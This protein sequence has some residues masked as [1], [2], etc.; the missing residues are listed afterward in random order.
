[1][2]PIRLDERTV[3][4]LFRRAAQPGYRLTI[5]LAAQTITDA[6]GLKL[7]F[8]IDPFRKHCLYNGLDDIGLTLEQVD[9]IAAYEQAHGMQ[10]VA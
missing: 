8:D 9:K 4:D 2:L 1:M 5:D 6:S 10:P 7:S 3:D